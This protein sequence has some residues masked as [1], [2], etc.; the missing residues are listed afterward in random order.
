MDDSLPSVQYQDE[1]RSE[2]FSSDVEMTSIPAQSGCPSAL[3][4]DESVGREH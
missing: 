4:Q 1:I 2:K 3:W